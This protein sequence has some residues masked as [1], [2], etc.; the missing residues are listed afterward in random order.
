M[1]ITELGNVFFLHAVRLSFKS[2]QKTGRVSLEMVLVCL[3]VGWMRSDIDSASNKE[4]NNNQISVCVLCLEKR[5]NGDVSGFGKIT[6]LYHVA[7][8][9]SPSRSLMRTTKFV[10]QFC[11]SVMKCLFV[12]VMMIV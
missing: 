3:S 10:Y 8:L 1:T 12:C 7:H 9:T 11:L 6:E 5:K 2:V 4:L